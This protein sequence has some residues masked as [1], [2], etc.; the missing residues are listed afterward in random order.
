MK[1]S[2]PTTRTL[3]RLIA[4]SA[5]LTLLPL[6]ASSCVD[7]IGMIDRTSPDKIEKA[8]F[9]GVWMYSQTTVDSPY[10]TSV[11]FTGE[12][13]F[14]ADNFKII[15]DIQESEL[16]A[17]PIVEKVDG[18]EKGWRVQ[19]VRRYWDADNRD[20]FQ[21][22]YVGQPVAIWPIHSHFD[23]NRKYNT[24][25]GA[26][27]NE[28]VEN[29]SD[30]PW[31]ERDY[32]RVDWS[33]QTMQPFFYQL[34]GGVG[35]LSYFAGDSKGH[36]ADSMTADAEGGYFDYVVT[37]MVPS[38]GQGYCSVYKL[39]P[40]DCTA[41]N[42]KVRHSFRRMDPRRDYEP[43]RYHNTAEQ[44]KFGFF[45]TARPH[46]DEDYGPSY[47]GSLEW[48]NRWN[49]W[50]NSYDFVYP[51][52]A[53]GR[54][55][56]TT[57]WN[58]YD[59]DEDAGQR[60]QKEESWFDDGTCMIPQPKK[61]SERGHRPI[62]YHLNQDWHPDYI[63]EA[64]HAAESWN[65]T[66]REAI[67]WQLFYEERD[68]YGVRACTVHSDCANDNLLV[69]IDAVVSSPG[70]VC[71]TDTDCGAD[72]YCSQDLGLCATA[73]ACD[74]D[75][76]CALGQACTAGACTDNGMPVEDA[77]E[78]VGFRGSSVIYHEGG[79]LVTQDAFYTD[80]NAQTDGDGDQ[81]PDFAWVRFVNAAP[82]AGDVGLRIACV[83]QCDSKTCGSD[84]CGGT[85]G[86]CGSDQV[87]TTQGAC[88]A[89]SGAA[90]QCVPDCAGKS[91]CDSNG[92]GGVCDASCSDLAAVPGDGGVTPVIIPGGGYDVAR[93]Y[94]PQNPA[95]ADFMALAPNVTGLT[96]LRFEAR[97]GGNVLASAGSDIIAGN[98][99]TVIFN[100]EDVQIFAVSFPDSAKGVRFIH[101]RPNAGALDFAL[102]GVRLKPDGMNAPYGTATVYHNIAGDVQRAT[103]SLAGSRGDFTCYT[104]DDVGRCV[105]WSAEVN[106]SDL[107]R[108]EAIKAGIP[109][110]FVLCENSYDDLTATDQANIDAA[111]ATKARMLNGT[112]FV[113][114]EVNDHFS[115]AWWTYERNGE[116]YNPCGDTALV[117]HPEQEK[118]IGDIRYSFFYWVDE[119]Q[120]SGP[121]GY[122]PSLAD[123]DTGQLITATAN[124]YGG[125]VHT[126]SQYAAD[127]VRMV[128]GEIDTDDVITGQWVRDALKAKAPSSPNFDP[129]AT[130][131][132]GLTSHGQEHAHAEEMVTMKDGFQIPKE[133]YESLEVPQMRTP[134]WE[135]PELMEFM[136][137]P[138]TFKDYVETSL[139]AMDP[140]HNHMR[141]NKLKGTWIE[142]LMING[143]IEFAGAMM[144]PAGELSADELK[145]QMSPLT[146]GSK[147]AMRV[148]DERIKVLARNNLY[149][150]EFV[151]D[152]LW[153]LAKELDQ[154]GFTGDALR[155]EIG[156]RILRGVLEHE[157]GHTVGLRHNFSGSVDI[158]NF[159]EEWYDAREKDLIFCKNDDTCDDVGGETCA[160]SDCTTDDD[161]ILGTLCYQGQCSGPEADDPSALTPTG[162]CSFV[163]EDLTCNNSSECE[164]DESVC[165]NGRCHV[166][167]RQYV[168]RTTITDNEKGAR[169]T[170]YQYSTC[171]DYG[172]RFNSD[173]HG[174]GKYDYAAIMF[175]YTQLVET[176]ADTSKVYERVQRASDLTGLPIEQWSFYLNT[177]YW[178]N[179]GMGFFHPFQYLTSYIGV[180]ENKVRIPRPWEQ[181]QYQKEMVAND[182][183]EWTDIE[184][185]E[186]PYAYCSDEF[187]GNMG[188]YIFDMGVD[189]GEMARHARDQLTH[190]YIF[191]AF[192]R[193]RLFYGDY[194]NPASYFGRIYSRYFSVLGDVGMFFA[195]YDTLLFRYSWYD[196]W[197]DNP[198]GG[199]SMERSA[200]QTFGY[201][202]DVVSSPAPGSYRLEEV[203]PGKSAYVNFDLETGAEGSE[204]DIPLG[205][206][207]FPTT[208]FSQAYGYDWNQHPLWFGS[209][210]EKLG[211][212]MTLTDSTAY[213]VDQSVGEQ[214]NIGVGTSLGYNTVF[215]DE[216]NAF[217]G[218]IIADEMDLYSGRWDQVGQKYTPP[219]IA[220]AA[221]SGDVIEPGLNNFTLKL[222]AAVYGLAFLPA[223]FDPR[224]IDSTAVY[225]E[226]EATQYSH[227]D[228]TIEEHR[229][230]DPVG[231]KVY[232]AYSNNYG[233]YDAVKISSGAVLIDRAQGLANQW[234][235]A[236]GAERLDLERQM[237]DIREILDVLR[238]LNHIYGAS[239]LG[240]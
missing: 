194:G 37:T 175:G 234:K 44:D 12:M 161:C 23:L 224:F 204:L 82:D 153:G 13:N 197:K 145:E 70:L 32:I 16:I 211:A 94:D 122:G 142:D 174:L 106:A 182:V 231:G 208:Q 35:P 130:F 14:F 24:Y 170:E 88:E 216:M 66:F 206:G 89:F 34:M 225:L 200:L 17:Y 148:E 15:F 33:G 80:T 191:D 55:I 62:V 114:D 50:M 20:T 123:P 7:Q 166:P 120:R 29:T 210:W 105:G 134:E 238:N 205:V 107:E 138:E 5:C 179:R 183:R 51:T 196:S 163:V 110:L 185:L 158:F 132:G 239:T 146:W 67:S 31:Y 77:V 63:A 93:D 102:A 217:L 144:D 150:G 61:Y 10:S 57:C 137:H 119:M 184:H 240:L 87:C 76:P 41:A 168:P 18:S 133:V 59:C 53:E 203:A 172:G 64:Y 164:T 113:H 112:Q 6:A 47:Y 11:S 193:E 180:E 25:N 169:R 1:F 98:S 214:L 176:Y 68:E 72:A 121:L 116:A 42:V 227:D 75:N 233:E 78:T 3:R 199:A 100:G 83:P 215:D 131:Q 52:D 45:A 26:Q 235:E 85:C 126:Y 155:L 209:F 84:G 69:D 171:M 129:T 160:I 228:P 202:Q 165:Y 140:S 135:Y 27:S 219:S 117:A 43:I 181:V 109:D 40:Y 162:V 28:L 156:R 201:L 229:F 22:M 30:R 136:R 151:D 173:F 154:K 237:S 54:E 36:E 226:G 159:H 73:R 9:E 96:G 157:I 149:M 91:G 221:P 124:I 58:D 186:V 4:A 230:I 222:Y 2:F 128:N 71:Y 212:L 101:S 90:N 104:K 118:R 143:E 178:P 213:F 21:E 127:L 207:R 99:Y 218:G 38:R 46:Y 65:D 56:V 192:K 152:A 147:H 60:C 81:A 198:M 141:L 111:A 95:T 189:M 48:A 220:L 74:Q 177:D 97:Q 86:T 39:S 49:L 187:R 190:Y 167:S 103:V 115:N 125:V 92:C 195:F 19:Q 108:R 79:F 232:V 223:G 188:C 236:T 8:L 139:P